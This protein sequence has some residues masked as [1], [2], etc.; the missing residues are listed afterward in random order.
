MDKDLARFMSKVDKQPGKDGCWLYTA[1]ILDDGYGA[2]W[3]GGKNYRAH[4]WIFEQKKRPLK[5]GEQAL[6]ICNTKRCVR[7]NHLYGGTHVDNMRDLRKSGVLQ[8]QPKSEAWKAQM[9][10]SMLGNKNGKK[11]PKHCLGCGAE[12]KN[13]YRKLCNPCLVIHRKNAPKWRERRG[14]VGRA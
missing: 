6:H 7:P 3:C 14:L 12:L 2:F 10:K 8:G 4:R 1:A 13:R 5:D 11:P 9:R